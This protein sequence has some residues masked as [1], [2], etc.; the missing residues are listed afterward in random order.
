MQPRVIPSA[1]KDTLIVPKLRK[2]IDSKLVFKRIHNPAFFEVEIIYA[3]KSLGTYQTTNFNEI[4]L[5]FFQKLSICIID[6]FFRVYFY[7]WF[8]SCCFCNN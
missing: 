7:L 8:Y 5:I 2:G 3:D 4:I 1:T 6:S